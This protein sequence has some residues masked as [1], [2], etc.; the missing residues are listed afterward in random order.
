MAN[1]PVPGTEEWHAIRASYIGGSEVAALFYRYRS[2]DG[3]EYV[4]HA[5]EAAPPDATPLGC[6]SKFQTAMGLWNIKAGVVQPPDLTGDRIDAGRYLEP[7]LAEWAAQKWS[8][9]IRKVR[10]YLKHDEVGGWGA[11]LDFE[12][13][14]DGQT[15]VPVEIKNVDRGAFARDWAVEGD[16]IVAP[17]LHYL[18][19]VQHQIGTTGADHGWI[20]ACVGGNELRRG[21]I[22]RHE[23]TQQRI[24]EAVREFWVG[25]SENV[26]PLGVADYSAVSQT[27][28]YGDKE[29]FVDLT[30]DADLPGLIR[31]YQSAR[32]QSD[33]H[34]ARVEALKGQIAARLGDATRAFCGPIRISWPVIN[35]AEKMIPARMQEA[36]TYRG[37]LTISEGK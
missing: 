25:V 14:G 13:H 2:A 3:V 31:A 36:K 17:P 15:G 32:D 5:Y 26:P 12:V 16:E 10:R 7:A 27:Y 34:E 11:S 23:P 18:L 28:A 21:R 30:A 4:L 1:I 6:V 29:R 19:Q 8:W 22:A 20:V 33:A 24:A 35:R 9:P 37:A